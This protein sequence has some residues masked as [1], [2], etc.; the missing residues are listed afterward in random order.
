MMEWLTFTFGNDW[1]TWKWALVLGSLPLLIMRGRDVVEKAFAIGLSMCAWWYYVGYKI[2]PGAGAAAI[3]RPL[4]IR[5]SILLAACMMAA[6]WALFSWCKKNTWRRFSLSALS[7]SLFYWNLSITY[8]A[9]MFEWYNKGLDSVTSITATLLAL[10]FWHWAR[11]RRFF[12][13]PVFMVTFYV[14]LKLQSTVGIV[15]LGAGLFVYMVIHNPWFLALVAPVLGGVVWYTEGSRL[16]M[17]NGRLQAAKLVVGWL[18]G[19][20]PYGQGEFGTLPY[21]PEAGSWLFGNGPGSFWAIFPNL[22]VDIGWI[23]DGFFVFLHNDILQGIFEFGLIGLIPWVLVYAISIRRC[24]T[25]SRMRYLPFLAAYLPAA[26]G[27]YPTH[28]AVEAFM[29]I[30]FLGEIYSWTNNS[31]NSSFE[32]WTDMLTRFRTFTSLSSILSGRGRCSSGACETGSP[33]HASMNSSG[34]TKGPYWQ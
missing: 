24:F 9:L 23:P 7:T 19:M 20:R 15:A 29:I 26:L 10:Q 18:S 33:A 12:T 34:T 16:L 8:L 14:I 6:S 4:S 30:I 31:G 5:S 27:Y 21:R 28:L 22:Q 17:E 3:T 13:W 1:Y 32:W 2:E 11:V 25:Y